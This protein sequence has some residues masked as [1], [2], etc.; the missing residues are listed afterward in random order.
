MI[1]GFPEEF[2]E[3]T[4]FSAPDPMAEKQP[5]IIILP[6]WHEPVFFFVSLHLRNTVGTALWHVEKLNKRQQ[7]VAWPI[8]SALHLFK[9]Y[10]STQ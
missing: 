7:P 5:C 3:F 4:F 8:F 2:G 6:L 9:T 10:I 1:F